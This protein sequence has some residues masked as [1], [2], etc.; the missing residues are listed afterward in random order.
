M[1][2]SIELAIPV[3]HHAGLRH[4]EGHEC[5]DGE[6]G[7]QPIGD[8]FE[9]DEQQ[10]GRCAE[11]EDTHRE[12]EAP[13]DNRERGGKETVLGNN[14]A[15]PRKIGKAG[16]RRERQNAQHAPDRQIVEPAVADDSAGEL[17]QHA[18]VSLLSLIHGGDAIHRN[19]ITDAREQDPKDADDRGE[20][21]VPVFDVRFTERADPV[22]HRLHARHCGTTARERPQQSPKSHRFRGLARRRRRHDWLGVPSRRERRITAHGDQQ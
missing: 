22:A 16:V 20:C 13:A 19:E 4:G 2:R 18:L 5:T 8:P 11:V 17:R 1:R 14:S 21:A 9:D 10:S 7:Y 12:H 6:E 15:H 3:D